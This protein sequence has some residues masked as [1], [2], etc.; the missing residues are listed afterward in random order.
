[1]LTY[2]RIVGHQRIA[3]RSLEEGDDDYNQSESPYRIIIW[4]DKYQLHLVNV[5]SNGSGRRIW[6]SQ[7]TRGRSESLQ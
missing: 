5:N 2:V 3:N 1:M 4:A 7:Q 6:W